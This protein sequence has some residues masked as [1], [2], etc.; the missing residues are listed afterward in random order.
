MSEPS[1]E[2]RETMKE[3]V[4]SVYMLTEMNAVHI[5]PGKLK[6]GTDVLIMCSMVGAGGTII[7]A[8]NKEEFYGQPVD[9]HPLCVFGDQAVN[10]SEMLMPPEGCISDGTETLN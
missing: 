6:D 8:D 10:T 5:V 7:T 1:D 9:V 3:V 4:R 2:L